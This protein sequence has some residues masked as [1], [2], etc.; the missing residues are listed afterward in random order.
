MKYKVFQVDAFS[1]GPFSGNPAAVIPLDSWLDDET[2]QKIADEINLSETAFFVRLENGHYQLRWFTPT[3]EVRLCGHATLATAH[4]LFEH[5]NEES[6]EIIFSTKS[7]DLLVKQM[8]QGRYRMNFPADV[9]EKIEEETLI[10]EALGVKPKEYYRGLDDY[11]VLLQSEED[12]LNLEPN[13][14]KLKKLDSRGMIV[15]AKGNE[16]DF[17][18]RGFFPQAGIDEDPATGSAHTLLTP[19]WADRLNKQSFNAE[20]LSKRRGFFSCD[21]EGDRVILTGDALTTIT[22]ELSL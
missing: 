13:F 4:V 11:L 17:V 7:G 6:E 9:P 20:Q 5:F 1:Q 21:L 3:V 15:T 10:E 22:G 14:T 16:K 2:L 19:F 12:V 8:E 18:S